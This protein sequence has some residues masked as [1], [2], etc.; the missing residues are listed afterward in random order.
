MVVDV[1]S[2]C[3]LRIIKWL[4]HRLYQ[5]VKFVFSDLLRSR[6]LP[7]L[8]SGFLPAGTSLKRRLFQQQLLEI[9]GGIEIRLIAGWAEH[10]WDLL[11]LQS[12]KVNISEKLMRDESLETG[13]TNASA[14]VLFH[15]SCHGPQTRDGNCRICHIVLWL[16]FFD[17]VT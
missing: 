8:R 15:Q 9:I 12:H 2:I 7:Q 13:R 1:P 17:V 4:K 16:G 14:S 11:S 3:H 5:A 6:I 10:R